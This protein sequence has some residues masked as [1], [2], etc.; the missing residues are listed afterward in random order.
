[1]ELYY[2]FGNLLFKNITFAYK[3]NIVYIS[4]ILFGY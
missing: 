2:F 3:T 1:M 4:V